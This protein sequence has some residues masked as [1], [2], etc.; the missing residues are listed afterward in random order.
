LELAADEIL[1]CDPGEGPL[2]C[3]T[4]EDSDANAYLLAIQIDSPV[5]GQELAIETHA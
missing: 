2:M 1:M 4:I 5:S 3:S